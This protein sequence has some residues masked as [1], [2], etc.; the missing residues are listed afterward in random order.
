MI[1]KSGE[2][3]FPAPKLM[4]DPN[5]L[6]TKSDS[7]CNNLEVTWFMHLFREGQLDVHFRLSRC[8]RMTLVLSEMS[9][10]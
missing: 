4:T 5:V 10:F 3:Q 2:S 1:G 8:K 9:R 6:S 7:N